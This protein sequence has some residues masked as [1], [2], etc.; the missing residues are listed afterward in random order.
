MM[1]E[2]R[3]HLISTLQWQLCVY[4]VYATYQWMGT[5]YAS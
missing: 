1:E 2:K 4:C 5:Y 3:F